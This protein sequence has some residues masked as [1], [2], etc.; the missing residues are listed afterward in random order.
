LQP[1][2]ILPDGT[3]DT[4]TKPIYGIWKLIRDWENL[5]A[6]PERDNYEYAYNNWPGEIGAPYIDVNSDGEFTQGIDEPDYIGDMILF[7]VANDMDTSL[8]TFTYGTNPMGLEFQ[9]SVYGFESDDDLKNVVFKKYRM[10]NKGINTIEDMFFGYW[11]DNDLG[12]AGDDYSGCDTILDFSYTYNG[13]NSDGVYGIAPAVGHKIIQGPIA[14]GLPTDS[15]KFKGEW[16]KG[17]KN[18]PP[19]AFFM[20]IGG[21]TLLWRDPRQGVPEG[22]IDFYN[23]LNGLVWDGSPVIDPITGDTTKFV[24]AGD[25]YYHTGWYEGSGWPGGPAKGDRRQLISTGPFNFAPGDTQEVAVA[26]L[27]AQGNDNVH[28][29]YKLKQ[30]AEKVQDFYDNDYVTSVENIKS[31]PL[32]FTLSQNYPNPFNPTTNIGFRIAEFGFVSLKVFDVLGREV[33]T[34]VNEEKSKG[35]YEVEFD[36]SQLSS[37]IYFYKLQTESNSLTKKMIYLK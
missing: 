30:L 16:R 29:V 33:A 19:N 20:Y 14:E 12:D 7:Y 9:T 4:S 17:Y 2:I 23:N 21:V 15:A 25:P 3:P 5:P 1:G 18:L 34:L 10:I 36:A 27:I 32:H 31:I 6:G 11:S 22:S 24:V 26:I 35:E 28:G 13:D 37:G 8:S